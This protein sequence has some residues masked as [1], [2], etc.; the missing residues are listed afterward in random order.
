[1]HRRCTSIAYLLSPLIRELHKDAGLDETVMRP[2]GSMM[3]LEVAT[4]SA[5]PY[6]AAKARAPGEKA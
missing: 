3:A 5:A 6:L 1:V 2:P 4:G